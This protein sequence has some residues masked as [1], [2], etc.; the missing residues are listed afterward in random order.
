MGWNELDLLLTGG[1]LGPMKQQLV[2]YGTFG[3]RRLDEDEFNSVF[4]NAGTGIIRRECQGCRESHKDIYIKVASP[5]DWN[6]YRELLVLWTAAGARQLFNL[7]STLGDARQNRN[8]WTWFNGNGGVGFPRDSGPTGRVNWQWNVLAGNRGQ[9]NFRFS[10]LQRHDPRE[11]DV[12]ADTEQVKIVEE[13]IMLTPHFHTL[14][15]LTPLGARNTTQ[16]NENGGGGKP[17]KALV[18][19]YLYGGADTFNMLV[20]LDCHLYGE[21]ESIRTTVALT[22][23]KLERIGTEGQPCETFGIHKQ[24]GIVKQLY[25][26]GQAAF[27]TNVGNLVEPILGHRG[28]MRCPGGFSHS[29]MQHASQT[30]QCQ[31]GSMFKLGGGGRMA[32]ALVTGNGEFNVASFS[33]AGKAPWSEGVVTKRNVISGNTAS[34]EGFNP[35]QRVQTIID[36]LTM[37]E[38]SG[39]YANE[40]TKQF[41]DS[42]N[43]YKRVAEALETGNRNL[44]MPNADY[45]GID[46][47]RTVAK[48]IAARASRRAE[49]DFFLVGFG[50]WDMHS[51]LESRLFGRFGTINR[52]VTSFVAEMRAQQIWDNVALAT[53][54]DFA[55]TLDPNGNIG[56]DHAWAGQH[57]ILSGSV[58]GGKIY[59]DFPPSLKAGNA[60]DVGRGRLI[61]KY[62][63]ESFMVPVAQWLGVE[64]SQLNTVFPNLKNFNGSYIIGNL[65]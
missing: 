51:G 21:Y 63:Y 15:P 28:A 43:G 49:R 24:L 25:D 11:E 65:F 14:G 34:A 52:V 61:P 55:R 32:D 22:P 13:A 20:P 56:T 48:L 18:I 7:Y 54:S 26:E 46:A 3:N 5:G 62:P 31:S 37:I 30:L 40:Y 58:K 27:V 42:V 50:G 38:F 47:L 19:L 17:Y 4:R 16:E 33:L 36:N 35:G 60:Q 64:N 23:E 6:A 2:E 41:D 45:G 1:R 8:P 59:N 29:D 57:F 10:V 44:R 12:E 39:V 53:M 9:R